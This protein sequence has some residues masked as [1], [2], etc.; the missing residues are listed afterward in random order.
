ERLSRHQGNRKI[1]NGVL[2]SRWR[3]FHYPPLVR[4]AGVRSK[5]L[6]SF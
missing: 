1:L 2:L 3:S 4:L 5:R 6:R